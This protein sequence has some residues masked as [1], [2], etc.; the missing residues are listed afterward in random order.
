MTESG[1]YLVLNLITGKFYIGSG[2]YVLSRLLSHK[3][4]S[5]NRRLREDIENLGVENF[6][7]EILELCDK[8]I[9]LLREQFWLDNANPEYNVVKKAGSVYGYKFTEEQLK[10][11]SESHIGQ[12][13]FWTGKNRDTETKLKISKSKKNNPWNP[14][15]EARAKISQSLSTRIISEE[16]RLKL[17]ISKFG[18]K[19][20]EGVIFTEERKRKI[21]LK[22]MGNQNGRKKLDD[23]K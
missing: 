1:I 16:T 5:H 17:S 3:K 2:N 14:S 10:R 6:A 23:I 9:L 21:S 7:F 18:N 4:S 15:Q 19:H 20:G 13:G 12:P 8:E 22:L 11:L